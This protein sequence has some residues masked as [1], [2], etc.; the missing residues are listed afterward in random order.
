MSPKY[1]GL[2]GLA[3]ALAGIGFV[4][5]TTIAVVADTPLY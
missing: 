4:V 5:G 1:H 2:Y 3:T